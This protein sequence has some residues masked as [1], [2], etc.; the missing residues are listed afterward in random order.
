VATFAPASVAPTSPSSQREGLVY[1]DSAATSQKP[2][3]S[4]TR[5]RTSRAPQRVGAPRRLP[6]GG[7]GDRALRGG[8]HARRALVG[9]AARDTILT[10]N[11]TQAINLVAQAWGRANL[12]PGDRVVVTEMEHH[13]VI[14]P[15]HMICRERGASSTSSASTTTAG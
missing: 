9:A 3:R 14:V 13:S 1:L 4:S 8:P 2:R 6:A 10:G 7:R 15:W 11:A 12:E 5:W